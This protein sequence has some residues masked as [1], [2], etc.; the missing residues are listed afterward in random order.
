MKK[1]DLTNL[2]EYLNNYIKN[3]KEEDIIEAFESSLTYIQEF[4]SNIPVEKL[5]YKYQ[6]EKWTIKEILCHLIDSERIISYRALRFARNDKNELLGYDQDEYIK[7]SEANKRSVADLLE[8]FT[9][10]RKANIVLF[11]SFNNEM[12]SRIGI[13]NKREISVIVLG[14]LISG[15]V[16]HHLNVI[17]ERYLI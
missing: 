8:D 13:A 2:S 12:L 3:V 9:L 11:K 4:I 6:P 1:S 14:F 16:L 5:E 17:K 7:Y 10:A 15:H